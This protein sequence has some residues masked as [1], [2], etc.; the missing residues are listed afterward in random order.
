M[1]RRHALSLAAG[2]ALLLLL[3]DPASGP[4]AD[5]GDTLVPARKAH[6][7]SP[8][9]FARIELGR[10]LFFDPAASPSG[11][12]SCASCHAPD[13]GWSDPA[14]VSADDAG[15]TTRHSQTILDA[16]F[17]PTAHWDG[18]FASVEQLVTTRLSSVPTST[19][20]GG[21]GRGTPFTPLR[22]KG[23]V[24]KRDR[25][26]KKK[27]KEEVITPGTRRKLLTN[28]PVPPNASAQVAMRLMTSGRYEEAFF[29]V[30]KKKTIALPQIAQAIAAFVHSVESTTAPYDHFKA[31]DLHALS[32]SAQRGL[33]LFEG[34]AGCAQ[35]HLTKGDHPFFTD[36]AFH[37]TGISKHELETF[38]A[39]AKARNTTR[40]RALQRAL[41]RRMRAAG[42]LK[43]VLDT[44]ADPGRARITSK[45]A[46][47]RTFKT[48]TLRDVA[49]R[50]PYMHNGRLK[51]LHDV[52]RYYAVGG[53]PDDTKSTRLHK[54]KCSDQDT[55]DLVA[56]LESLSGAERPGQ[57]TKVWTKRTRSTRLAF[58][59]AGGN[60]ME[61]L[62][63]RLVPVGDVLPVLRAPAESMTTET[64]DRSGRVRFEP[65]ATT[66]TRIVLPEG[67][68]VRGGGLIPDTCSKARIHVPIAGRMTFVVTFPAGAAAP[69]LLLGVHTERAPLLGHPRERTRFVRV[70]EAV[71]VAG[72]LVAKYKGWARTD[73]GRT[74]T[75]IVPGRQTLTRGSGIKPDLR[76]PISAGAQYT[77]DL[78]SE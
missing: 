29:A 25:K 10:R 50:G 60:P 75:L 35:C 26:T 74:V 24:T 57:A 42:D 23:P 36:F 15:T 48:P 33:T 3:N 16:A 20:G 6:R 7:V 59:D 46:E 49:K 55:E 39:S 4:V 41:R 44:L 77:L 28:V 73:V 32:T 13:H 43:R 65:G 51:T 52:V 72:A 40:E 76:Y 61:D 12:R 47:T 34:R 19:G 68:P 27:T 14:R 17:N 22:R 78:R 5:A 1:R 37:N 31:G 62:D 30:F 54:F 8:R 64:T 67:L 2:A 11:A 18:E 38:P 69:P 66:H 71:E 45:A 53:G 9:L 58:V 70:G 21:Y 63:V 56:F